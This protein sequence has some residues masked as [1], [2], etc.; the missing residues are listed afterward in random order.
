[1]TRTN[2]I[3]S[4]CVAL[5]T[6]VFAQG[7]IPVPRERIQTDLVK[8]AD[9]TYKKLNRPR[10][11]YGCRELFT[12][13]LAYAEAGTNLTRIAELLT[14]AEKMQD[15]DPS[16]RSYGNLRWYSR[17]TDVMDYNAVDFCMQH[18]ALLWKF[19]REALDPAVR[20]RLRTLLAL[21]LKGLI[22]HQPRTTYTN[23]ALLNASDLI[24]LGETLGD[25]RAV[26]EGERRLDLFIKTLWEEGA[27]EYVSPTYYGVDVES[28]MLVEA[29]AQKKETRDVARALLA[30]FWTDI[31]LNWFAPAQRLCGA[32]SRT[33]D[34]VFGAGEL[35]QILAATGWLPCDKRFGFTTFTPLYARWLPPSDLWHLSVIRYPRL[36][37]QTWGAEPFCSRTHYVCNDVTLSTAWKAYI[38]RMD[39]ALAADFPGTREERLPRLSFIP[40]GRRDPYGK[41][42]VFDG[43]THSKAFHLDPWWAGVQD[44][45]DALGVAVYRDSDFKDATGTL[46]SHLLFRKRLDSLWINETRVTFDAKKPSTHPVPAGA[47]VFLR[48]GTAVIG[49]R[50]PWSRGQDGSTSPVSI[51]DDNT[52][53]GAARLTVSHAWI[54]PSNKISRVQAGVA[55]WLRVGSGIE[56]DADFA[57]FRKTFNAAPAEIAATPNSLRIQV[58]GLTQPLSIAAQAPFTGDPATRPVPPRTVLGLDGQDIGCAALEKSP[59]IQAYLK[60]RRQA[61]PIAVAADKPTVWEAEQA[62]FTVPYEAATNDASASGHAFLW[63]PETDGQN[64][65][66]GGRAT[67]S[68]EVA[69][70]GRYT[71]AGRVLTPTPENDSFFLSAQTQ[72]GRSLL[73][74]TAWCP[75]V[76][77]TW[78]WCDFTPSGKRAPATLDLP[79]GT[80]ILILRPREAGSKLDQF[81]LTPLPR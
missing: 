43:K 17:D 72:D 16:H 4:I 62:P 59:V 46:D 27:H 12:S 61:V 45:A 39:I 63:V 60:T 15:R 49:I 58:S 8:R 68:L 6:S 20:E 56:K 73:P 21:G 1:M 57:A 34:Y 66:G 81:R 29:L 78:S 30:Y 28:M 54:D 22:K 38:G 70:A 19:H 52:P 23:I 41:K 80:V 35:D 31:A 53:F 11:N 40:D 64:S 51:V 42:A 74:E 50:V 55:F 47:A 24:L 5:S 10:P 65:S 9:D 77:K 79:R 76:H 25:A 71:L 37:E 18:G 36:I 3:A 13:M 48:Q 2:L 14:F 67:Y 32:H 44:R 26:S 75:G 69:S 33:Y 7:L